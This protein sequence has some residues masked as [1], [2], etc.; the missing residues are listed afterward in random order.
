[1]VLPSFQET[2]LGGRIRVMFS[3]R[4]VVWYP[5]ILLEVM[6]RGFM[7]RLETGFAGWLGYRGTI[8]LRRKFRRL[9]ELAG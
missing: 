6:G 2:P 1:M 9:A 8:G 7:L 3:R 4:Q 5:I